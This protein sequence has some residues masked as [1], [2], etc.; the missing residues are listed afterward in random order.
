MKII[1][2]KFGKYKIPP[3]LCVKKNN[4]NISQTK[5]TQN[6]NIKLNKKQ[7]FTTMNCQKIAKAAASNLNKKVLTSDWF[8]GTLKSDYS[9]KSEIAAYLVADLATDILQG[10]GEDINNGSREDDQHNNKLQR[11]TATVFGTDYNVRVTANM[12]TRYTL[13]NYTV[14]VTNADFDTLARFEF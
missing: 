5:F 11:A 8:L 6:E 10:I 3:Y 13:K 7:K 4:K 1:C 9:F 2:K 12:T 14:V